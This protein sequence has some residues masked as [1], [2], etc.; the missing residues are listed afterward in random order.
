MITVS[1]GNAWPS[2]T[3]PILLADNS[4]IP[5]TREEA[6]WIVSTQLIGHLMAP[7]PAAYLMDK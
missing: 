3:L 6:S 1:I 7:V 2:P 5:T 4:P